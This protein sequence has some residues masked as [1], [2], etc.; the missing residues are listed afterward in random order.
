MYIRKKLNRNLPKRAR[1]VLTMFNCGIR[2]ESV[3][4][5]Q[6][7]IDIILIRLN[8]GMKSYTS[9]QL[10]E[11]KECVRNSGTPVSVSVYRVKG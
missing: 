3:Y 1:C 8:G 10:N 9:G 7:V 2:L 5:K 4:L 11:S 6:L